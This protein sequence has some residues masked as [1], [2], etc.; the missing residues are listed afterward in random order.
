M[1][2]QLVEPVPPE[3]LAALDALL[4]LAD[5]SQFS[6][7]SWL[8]EP[9]G[10]PRARHI[11]AHLDRLK[12]VRLIGIPAGTGNALHSGRL[13]KL[14]REGAQMTSQ[15]LRDL[16]PNR[17]HATVVPVVLDTQATLVDE[18]IDLH[19]RYLGAVFSK[20][21]RTHAEQFQNSGKAISHKVR[22][23]SQLGRALLAGKI[24][25]AEP[26]AAVEKVIS[27]AALEE[28]RTEAE[29]L[30]GPANFDHLASAVDGCSQLRRYTPA[31]L[32]SLDFQATPAARDVLAAIVV[33]RDV[34]ARQARKIP[35]TA[36][37]SFVRKRWV[38]LVRDG[39]DRR[40]YELCV[41]SELRNS[42]RSGDISCSY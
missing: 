9:P 16:E 12:A 19:D 40:F 33:L 8:R 22:L 32:E 3:S 15:H 11:L 37:T 41:M 1:H 36:P 13:A 23:Y 25:G 20:A 17:R 5:G 21:K 30:A 4:A 28:S 24:S 14:A 7:L 2:E 10:A 38:D 18:I 27:W 29:Q 42:L 26:F 35:E 34:Y 6:R 39:L 31:R